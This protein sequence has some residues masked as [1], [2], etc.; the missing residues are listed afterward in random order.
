[1]ADKSQ[2]FAL[3]FPYQPPALGELVPIKDRSKEA[4]KNDDHLIN[5]RP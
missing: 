2:T 4:I 3:G 1:M 5:V